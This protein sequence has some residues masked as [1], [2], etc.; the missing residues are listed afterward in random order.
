MIWI[1]RIVLAVSTVLTVLFDPRVFFGAGQGGGGFIS[2]TSWF[3]TGSWWAVRL[4]VIALVLFALAA[5]TTDGNARVGWRGPALAVALIAWALVRGVP[6][7]DNV[8]S[9]ARGDVGVRAWLRT[10][11]E[12]RANERTPI[13]A[14]AFA[15][16]WH[17][18][19]GTE[20]RFAPNVASRV[21]PEVQAQSAAAVRSRCRGTFRVGYEERGRDVLV[22]TDAF[23]VPTRRR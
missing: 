9:W 18:A 5:L 7:R 1:A 12:H 6:H 22:E 14:E 4:A 8:S 3:H 17:S 11:R 23:R 19:D 20:W 2:F 15:G 10:Q 13:G 21:V 16:T